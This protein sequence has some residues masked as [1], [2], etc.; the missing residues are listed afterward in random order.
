MRAVF[1]QGARTFE[2][3]TAPVPRPGPGEAL[4]RVR[5]V[6]ICG[7]DLHIFQ[8]HLDHR[9]PKGG[10]I[11]HETF[12]E[13]AE[14]PAGSGVHAGDRVVV[15]PLQFCGTCRAC[16]MGASYICYA[17]K[18]LGVDLPGGMQEYWAVPAARLLRVPDALSDDHAAL[19]E[20]LAVATH[21]VR[22]AGV[23]AGDA[24]LVF[25]GG[26]IGT[27]IGLVARQRGA[28]VA[29]AE[30]NPFRL[31]MLE[32]L[33]FQTVGPGR[34]VGRFVEEWT[35]GDGADVAFEVT[36]NP[37]AVRL[38]TDVVRV[39]GTVSLVAIH[40]EPMPVNLYRMFFR[41]LTM[42]GSR[43]YAREDW[44][45]AIR[46]AAAGAVPLAPLVSRRIPLEA[47]QEGMEQALGGG[48]VMKV[49]VDLSA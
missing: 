39:W 24:A 18:V 29:V 16:R 7:T 38:V 20:P 13:V 19:I 17:L 27:L 44:E 5:R 40:A 35:G 6:G 23:K 25:G 10:V 3:G 34:D 28:R 31:A 36:G 4:L 42:H 32:T 47:L 21:D 12:A 26:P 9:V 14:A 45:E 11:G 43:L 48:P 49:L 15:E 37:A 2:P 30:V 41:E 22:R 8:G 46:L 1:Y 33:G